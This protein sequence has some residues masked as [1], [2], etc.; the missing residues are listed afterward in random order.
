M[1]RDMKHM[2]GDTWQVGSPALYRQ[3]NQHPVC[4][5]QV[6]GLQDMHTLT[7]DHRPNILQIADLL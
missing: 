3:A 5:L 2:K 4:S 7:A 1:T 6:W